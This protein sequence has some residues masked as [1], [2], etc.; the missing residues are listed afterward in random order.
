MCITFTRTQIFPFV[1][2]SRNR[3]ISTTSLPHEDL[4]HEES[5]NDPGV[6]P[7]GPRESQGTK[8]IFFTEV[9]SQD[10]NPRPIFWPLPT[11]LDYNETLC[12]VSA[13]DAQFGARHQG[14]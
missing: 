1:K 12:A 13:V 5:P 8:I 6:V 11:S 7:Y 9:C 10:L 3:T 14:D 4:E 2:F